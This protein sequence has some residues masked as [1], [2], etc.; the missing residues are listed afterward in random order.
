MG[1]G[2]VSGGLGCVGLQLNEDEKTLKQLEKQAELKTQIEA[3]KKKKVSQVGETYGWGA[4]VFGPM[5][6][7]ASTLHIIL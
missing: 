5:C 4:C 3:L 2:R 1:D 7:N 6:F